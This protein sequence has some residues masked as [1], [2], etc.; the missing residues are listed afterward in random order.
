MSAL[1]ID[2]PKPQFP[3]NT[4][5]TTGCKCLE[6]GRPG[7]VLSVNTRGEKAWIDLPQAVEA[8]LG[9]AVDSGL[10]DQGRIPQL[11]GG[12]IPDLRDKYLTHDLKDVPGGVAGLSGNGKI[13]PSALPVLPTPAK[14]DKG[15]R[16]EPGAAGVGERG[17]IGPR[18]EKG[19]RG[20]QGV[21]GPEG[22]QGIRGPQA[23][24]TGLLKKPADPPVLMLSS[25]TLARDVAYVLAE[26]GLAKLQ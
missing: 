23:D 10:I 14:G 21:P 3:H 9:T 1:D 18:G 19:E 4:A 13:S 7:Q 26:H 25:D 11:S 15:D 6:G 22:Q 24:L 20:D 8:T 2:K 16:G 5:P 12:H 17:P